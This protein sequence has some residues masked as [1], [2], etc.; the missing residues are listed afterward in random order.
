VRAFNTD[1]A[2]ADAARNSL[3]CFYLAPLLAAAAEMRPFHSEAA[4]TNLQVHQR[5]PMA[6]LQQQE[7]PEHQEQLHCAPT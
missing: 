2:T 7:Q 3:S 6:S 5:R 4:A 1:G